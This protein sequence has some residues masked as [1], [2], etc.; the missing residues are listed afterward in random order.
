VQSNRFFHQICKSRLAQYLGNIPYFI[1]LV[2][3]FPLIPIF[4]WNIKL[5]GY[6]YPKYADAYS[7]FW[8]GAGY[9]L[10]YIHILIGLLSLSYYFIEKP[11]R[12]IINVRW[13][14]QQMPV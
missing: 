10:I 11:C 12:K 9:C 5:P 14:K 8:I 6:V 4:C 7:N 13:G 3:F 1:Y 2:Q